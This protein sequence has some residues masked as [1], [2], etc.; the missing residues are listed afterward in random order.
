ML[1]AGYSAVFPA[2]VATTAMFCTRSLRKR[3]LYLLRAFQMRHERGAHFDQQSL[4]FFVLG[5]G[6][7]RLIESIEDCLVIH[8]FVIDVGLVERGP[9]QLLQMTDVFGP[10]DLRLCA[11]G[12]SSG[13][14]P[15]LVT[16][17][18]A[19]LLTPE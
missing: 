18:V 1:I 8:D 3:G 10:P 16:S 7:E 17:C 5:A 12:L 11:V 19:S 4:Q 2:K 15:S 13:F 9:V 6:N 14:T